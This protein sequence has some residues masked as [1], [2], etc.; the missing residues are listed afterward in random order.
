MRK[1][2]HLIIVLSLVSA[3]CSSAAERT[4]HEQLN[5]V[6]WM[7]TSAEFQVSTVQAFRLAKIRVR[8]AL[9]DP[10]WT[11]ALEQSPEYKQLPPAVITDVDET[12]L[13]NSPFQARLV[14]DN[15]EFDSAGWNSWVNEARADALPG[16]KEFISFLRAN[17]VT[18]FYVTNRSQ[19]TPT[20]ENLRRVLDPDVTSEQVLCKNEEPGWGSDKTSR[21]A[22]LAKKYRILLLL[23]DDYND[24][25]SLGSVRPE[26]RIRKAQTQSDYWGRKWVLISN[27][28][29]GSWERALYGRGLSASDKL[30]SKYRFLKTK[31]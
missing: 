7:Q 13:D 11:A 4:T 9:L 25:T 2:G 30:I 6:L 26:E 31:N 29:Y 8:E 17:G 27:P 10:E 16:A 21:R 23:G 22:F 19:E 1:T 18:V 5:G 24:F 15:K 28:L 14:R 3:G 12:V 20:L